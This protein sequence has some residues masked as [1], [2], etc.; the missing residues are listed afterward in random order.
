MGTAVSGRSKPLQEQG[1]AKEIINP[2]ELFPSQQYGFS[3]VVTAAGGITVYLSG[4]VAWDAEQQIVGPGDLEVQTRQALENVR[5]AMEAAG[6]RLSDV[7]SMRIYIV[8][9]ALAESRQISQAL[10][11]TFSRDQAPATTW[12]GVRALADPEFLIEIEAVGV[13]DL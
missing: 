12:I 13:I 6:G 3:Q 5:T 9:S 4:Q 7:V 8:E 10:R 11:D 2:P 1:M